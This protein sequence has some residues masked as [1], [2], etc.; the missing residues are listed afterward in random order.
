MHRDIKASYLKSLQGYL[1]ETGYD[2]NELEA[3]LFRDVAEVLHAWC[4]QGL[5]IMIYSS[6]SVQAQRLFFRHTNAKPRDLVP[7]IQDFFDTVN[8]GPK[9]EAASY[10]RI[11]SRYP[12]FSMDEWLFLSDNPREV[13]AAQAA[14]MQVSVVHRPGNP[15]LPSEV[16]QRFRVAKSFEEI[17]I[18]P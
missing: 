12:Q 9:V 17:V 7:L 13:E 16:Q 14:G 1:W 18:S 5:T 11:A 2:N 6:G 15:T 4:D 3:P 10:Q 8:A